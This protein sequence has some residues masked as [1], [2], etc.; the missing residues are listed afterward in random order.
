LKEKQPKPNGESVKSD[1]IMWKDPIDE[2]KLKENKAD[3]LAESYNT[4]VNEYLAVRK[5]RDDLKKQY[6]A[7]EYQRDDFASVIK[8]CNFPELRKLLNVPEGELLSTQLLTRVQELIEERD[9]LTR[10]KNEALELYKQFDAHEIGK[11]LGLSL[12]TPVMASIEPEIRKL[13]KD[14]DGY[15]SD[16]ADLMIERD[17]LRKELDNV[18][19]LLRDRIEYGIYRG[20]DMNI[21]GGTQQ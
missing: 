4:M 11:L 21:R 1:W 20:P 6:E 18:R 7:L 12:G 19:S 14:R 9:D 13:I 2:C 16:A 5:E 17:S 8:E 15:K 10:W 3:Q